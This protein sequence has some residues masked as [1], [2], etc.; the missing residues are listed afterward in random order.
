MRS[1]GVFMQ[2][3]WTSLNW[4]GLIAL[5]TII[6]GV[7]QSATWARWIRHVL[8]GVAFGTG[9]WACMMNSI[10]V[11]PGVIADSRN[12]FIGFA[13]A[14]LGP[15][16]AGIAFSMAGAV[17]I[18]IGGSGMP[19]GLSS[20]FLAMVVGVL[21]GVWREK[22][23]G[24]SYKYL[25]IMG[26]TFSIPL[27]V[28]MIFLNGD[29]RTNFLKFTPLFI[30]IN[31]FGTILF[32][33]LLDRD[34]AKSRYLRS[35][36]NQS[37]KDPLTEALNRRGLEDIYKEIMTSRAYKGRGAILL[38]LDHFKSIN[39]TYGHAAGD[40]TIKITTKA[41]KDVIRAGDILARVGGEEFI[42]LF[43]EIS[44]SD[45]ISISE[46]IR[47]SIKLARNGDCSNV[48]ASIGGTYW[49]TGDRNL[50]EVMQTAD[51]MM[52]EA[53]NQGRDRLVSD[54]N[55]GIAAE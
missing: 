24:L 32:G 23:K 46:R 11:G 31:F 41:I 38:D 48:T 49:N 29:A 22:E 34:R 13:G 8:L 3:V 26:L 6:Y 36:L 10:E 53:K 17:R 5:I 30:A 47:M 54:L 28:G 33:K 43:P 50:D 18:S 4:I 2:A 7:V 52:Y 45:F 35:L 1:L 19:L 55:L 15:M 21:W 39:D 27:L 12:L 40:R 42:V 16:A 37:L 25:M 14:F 44:E 9:A 20:M 51:K